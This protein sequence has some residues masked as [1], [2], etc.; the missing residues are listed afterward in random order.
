MNISPA[1]GAQPNFTAL[2]PVPKLAK[3]MGGE[4]L[5]KA[6]PELEKMAQ[7]VDIEIIPKKGFFSKLQNL[8]FFV[9]NV[10]EQV[11]R[12]FSLS[13]DPKGYL[14][15]N[16]PTHYKQVDAFTK[17]NILESAQKAKDLNK[18]GLKVERKTIAM[19]PAD[20][21]ILAKAMKDKQAKA[22]AEAKAKENQQ[23]EK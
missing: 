23:T 9:T 1:M 8:N 7:D 22:E 11:G 20:A 3:K 21:V 16:D 13:I 10:G 14:E 5:E 12:W 2:K 4:A 6:M 17:E 19:M 15:G 18:K